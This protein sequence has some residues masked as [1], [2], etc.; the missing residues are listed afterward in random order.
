MSL[1]TKTERSAAHRVWHTPPR[2]VHKRSRNEH[3]YYRQSHSVSGSGSAQ[4]VSERQAPA[5]A[6][7]ALALLRNIKKV[8]KSRTLFI[9]A[10]HA[11]KKPNYVWLYTS[12]ILFSVADK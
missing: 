9:L 4:G 11:N 10:G 1:N 8:N 6:Y 7:A 2:N 12:N 3:Y 5:L